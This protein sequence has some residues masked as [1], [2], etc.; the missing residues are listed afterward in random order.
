MCIPFKKKELQSL[1]LKC[2]QGPTASNCRCHGAEVFT[3]V[4]QS[5]FKYC[6]SSPFPPPPCPMW[7][8]EILEWH[9]KR[10]F[11][12]QEKWKQNHH[13]P[14]MVFGRSVRLMN[15]YASLEAKRTPDVREGIPRLK[16]I[17]LERNSLSQIGLCLNLNSL[18]LLEDGVGGGASCP[19][20][21]WG[22]GP[23]S[24]MNSLQMATYT[25]ILFF[26]LN[27]QN[28]KLNTIEPLFWLCIMCMPPKTEE[29]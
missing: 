3:A 20:A 4:F 25:L 16:W 27:N 17:T 14:W 12:Q 15:T 23:H 10:H 22:R 11:S 28:T 1:S 6:Y 7:V 29:K 24:A 13:T 9:M 8:C 21:W 5:I 2:V 26:F 19:S 18:L